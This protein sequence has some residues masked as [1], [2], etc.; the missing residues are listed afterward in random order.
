MNNEGFGEIVEV[1]GGIVGEFGRFGE[2]G[3]LLGD[4]ADLSGNLG[5][6]LGMGR[7]RLEVWA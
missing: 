7:H 5:Q 4:W 1:F 6:L 3:A 2:L